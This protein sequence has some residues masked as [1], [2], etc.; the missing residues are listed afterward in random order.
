MDNKI[1]YRPRIADRL[2]QDKL[3]ETGAV[4]VEGPKW[5]GKTTTASQF[6]KSIIYMDDPVLSSQY[7]EMLNLQPD[8]LLAGEKPRLFDEW[9]I[10]PRLW[11]VIRHYI[12]RH[13]KEGLY[14]LTGSA[15]PPQT[16][17]IRH[18][19]TGRYSWL[20]MST[21]TFWESGDSTGAISLKEMFDN[22]PQSGVNN[23]DLS[24]IAYLICRGGWPATLNRNERAALRLVY[25]YLDAV[26]RSDIS[27]VSSTNYNETL[28][29]DILRVY[30]RM[31]GSQSSD[32]SILKDLSG[33]YEERIS[34]NTL[35]SYLNAFEKIFVIQDLK[36]WNPNL[37][38]KTAIRTSPTR[39]FS[40]PSIAVASLGLGPEDLIN[41]L[42]TF[43]LIF[44]TAAIR[45]LRVY[46]QA[47]DG[48]VY[49]YRDKN[50][51]ECD[52]VVHLRN[53]SY[54]LVEI[55]LGGDRGIEHAV[56][57]LSALEAK[58][59]TGRMKAPSFKMV[60]TAVGP[61]AYQRA[62]G[63]WVVPIG[64]LKN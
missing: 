53:G 15:V 36:A 39:Y 41:D 21:M 27:R 47:L 49:H 55:K 25:D 45:D 31:Q 46:A 62:D 24:R 56:S 52:A 18:S 5:C 58:I 33:K 23:L 57:T 60:L 54:G 19:G 30:A 16:D 12:D 28:C 3:E 51:L 10:E 43:G 38:S 50:G 6:A 20:T 1:E 35:R 44:E 17:E 37:R 32:T 9:Q 42:E 7:S 4:V 14:I 59:D 11:D 63:V 13:N 2:L 26:I 34:I 8:L 48:E 22:K 29:K 64:A 61:Y 40:D